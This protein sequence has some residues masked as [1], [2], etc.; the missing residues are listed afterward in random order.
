MGFICIPLA[1][2]WPGL[3]SSMILTAADQYPTVT[4]IT[5]PREGI[6][7]SPSICSSRFVLSRFNLTQFYLWTGCG[8]LWKGY[9]PET[10]TLIRVPGPDYVMKDN[11][12]DYAVEASMKIIDGFSKV[13]KGL[14]LVRC[15]LITDF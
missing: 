8:E 15:G 5:R 11:L 13:R 14:L 4:V 9:S 1:P 2:W 3:H 6:Q 7:I 12:A 10:H